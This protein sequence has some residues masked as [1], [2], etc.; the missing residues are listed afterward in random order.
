M[1]MMEKF[2]ALYLLTGD[3]RYGEEAKRRIIHF[4]SWDPLGPTSYY[5]NNEAAMWMLYK[6]VSYL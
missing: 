3:E 1:N 2:G 4:F 6:G 5:A